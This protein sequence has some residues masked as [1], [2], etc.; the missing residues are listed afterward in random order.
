MQPLSERM[1]TF[2][3]CAGPAVVGC[4]VVLLVKTIQAHVWEGESILSQVLQI[5]CSIYI[6]LAILSVVIQDYRRAHYGTFSRPLT[7]AQ[8]EPIRRAMEDY[9]VGTAAKIYRTAVPDA[10]L[11]EA[12]QYVLGLAASLRAQHPGKFVPLPLSLAT[13][14]WHA[15]L[16]CA[17][18]EAVLLGVWW[19]IMA[20]AH[21][22]WNAAQFACTF[23]FAMA[24]LACGR[25]QGFWKRML[26][27]VPAIVLLA[28][29]EVIRSNSANA[30]SRSVTAY[31]I[32]CGGFLLASG[33]KRRRRHV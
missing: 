4:G 5:Y 3:L 28:V 14:N 7:A 16:I 32:I 26:L 6:G 24:L 9:D 30:S 1:R 2:A 33:F 21:S 22:V 12:T 17:V 8:L 19:T 27:L 20:P 11:M 15:M 25:V 18:I 31:G 23:L 13:L 29:S 10:G